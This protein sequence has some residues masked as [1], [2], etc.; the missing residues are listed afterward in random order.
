MWPREDTAYVVWP[1]ESFS[2]THVLIINLPYWYYIHVPHNDWIHGGMTL[3]VLTELPLNKVIR[4][5]AGST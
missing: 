2:K 3:T 1:T 4:L 5:R